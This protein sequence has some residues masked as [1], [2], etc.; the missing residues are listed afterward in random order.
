MVNSQKDG[1]VKIDGVSH[2]V[3]VETIS[4]TMEI[5]NEGIKFYRD[6]KMLAN[7]VKDFA[8]NVKEKKKLVKVET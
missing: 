7:A 5:P 6:K 8:K 4:L 3:S 1:Q 2:Q